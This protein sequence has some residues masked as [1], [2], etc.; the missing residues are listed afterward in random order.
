M[1]A[2]ILDASAF[3]LQLGTPR[4]CSIAA[5]GKLHQR[6]FDRCMLLSHDSYTSFN[7]CLLHKS[8]LLLKQHPIM[9]YHA[10]LHYVVF[11]DKM[12][13]LHLA[14]R[15]GHANVVRLLLEAGVGVDKRTY[16]GSSRTIVLT[17]IPAPS[18]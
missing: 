9:V 1:V 17:V 2:G 10:W 8:A 13:A 15:S 16:V 7:M 3:G 18:L 11:Q 5:A 4:N 6:L 14:A 12:T